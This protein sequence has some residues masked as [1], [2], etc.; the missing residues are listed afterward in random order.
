MGLLLISPCNPLL[1]QGVKLLPGSRI[2][3]RPVLARAFPYPVVI[4]S[5]VA[6]SRSHNFL[7]NPQVFSSGKQGILELDKNGKLLRMI[8]LPID[9]NPR[10]LQ[11][12]EASK[13]VFVWTRGSA[14][15]PDM[16]EAVYKIASSGEITQEATFARG[17]RYPV[18]FDGAI[19]GITNTGCIRN[20]AKVESQICSIGTADPYGTGLMFKPFSTT[21]LVSVE[22][23]TPALIRLNPVA[24]GLVVRRIVSPEI[25]RAQESSRNNPTSSLLISDLVVASPQHLLVNVMRQPFVEGAAILKL[26]LNGD[27]VGSFRCELPREP[28]FQSTGNPGGYMFPSMIGYSD[29]TLFVVDRTGLLASCH[30]PS[31]NVAK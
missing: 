12:D 22:P 17:L 25:Q 16:K 28:V 31:V 7:V 27:T 3:L 29:A 15:G 30:L 13:A 24:G 21:E 8:P 5:F 23:T 4:G 2:D 18:H 26:D 6:S 1:A 9:V 11:F 19:W 10:W 20:G 14:V